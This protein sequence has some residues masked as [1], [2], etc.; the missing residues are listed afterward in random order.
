MKVYV[1]TEKKIKL[2][3]GQGLSDVIIDIFSPTNVKVFT[4]TMTEI[5][6]CVYSSAFTPTV[7][8]EYTIV[9]SSDST[10]QKTVENLISED[11]CGKKVW[12]YLQSETT[13]AGSMKDIVQT[14]ALRVENQSSSGSMLETILG[15]IEDQDSE[16]IGFVEDEN[17]LTGETND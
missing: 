14:T 10:G 17:E 7:I 4:E 1:N 13:V 11:S 2:E 8:G 3:A 16:L 6:P 5:I 12:D 15:F 9:I